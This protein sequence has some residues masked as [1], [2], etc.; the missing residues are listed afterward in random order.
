MLILS[1]K[2]LSRFLRS[3]SLSMISFRSIIADIRCSKS[4]W[5]PGRTGS[6]KS[7]RKKGVSYQY[8]LWQ[9]LRR[10]PYPYS[11]PILRH[12]RHLRQPLQCCCY[13]CR[14]SPLCPQHLRDETQNGKTAAFWYLSLHWNGLRNRLISSDATAQRF[15]SA[16]RT[17]ERKAGQDKLGLPMEV[18]TRT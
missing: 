4:C 1:K 15:V 9:R 16:V 7:L 18:R 12:H 5:I 10:V 8:H 2:T 11:I 14:Y 3:F 13:Y 6:T 17:T